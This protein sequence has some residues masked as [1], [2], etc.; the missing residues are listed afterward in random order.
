MTRSR[1]VANIDGLLTTKGDIYAAT[2]AATPDRLAVGA[3]DTVLTADSAQAT[4]LKWA[5]PVATGKNFALLNSGG[6]T[7]TGAATI[8]IS[9]I[10]ADQIMVVVQAATF[11]SGTGDMGVL[12]NG[13]TASNYRQSFINRVGTTF[14]SFGVNSGNITLGTNGTVLDALSG[15]VFISGCSTSGIKIFQGSGSGGTDA[16]S[17]SRWTGGA[18]TSAST[19]S[20]VSI[21]TLGG[22]ANFLSGTVYVYGAV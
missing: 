22:A 14:Q 18:Y 13:D 17:R 1:D 12:L 7:L 21:V 10:A 4:G 3:N 5:T 20:S 16:S 6:T 9:G 15:S 19:I 11:V 8:T 2:A